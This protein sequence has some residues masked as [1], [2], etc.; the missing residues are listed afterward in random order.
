MGAANVRRFEDLEHSDERYELAG[1]RS[2]DCFH[3][4][5]DVLPLEKP[6]ILVRADPAASA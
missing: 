2:G 6:V 3:R 4:A 5:V 1:E